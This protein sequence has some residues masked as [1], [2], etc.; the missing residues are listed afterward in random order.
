MDLYRNLIVIIQIQPY[1]KKLLFILLYMGICMCQIFS[2]VPQILKY[3]A[4]LRNVSGNP[5]ASSNKTIVVDILQGSTSGINVFSET[6]NV[7]TNESGIANLDIGSVNSAGFV[8]ID[9]SKG[10]YFLKIAVDGQVMGTSQ[11]LSVPY[12]LYADKTGKSDKLEVNESPTLS[13]DSALFEVKDKNGNIVF[14]V[15]ENGVIISYNEGAKGAR[16][17]FTVGGRT[18]GKG[19]MIENIF[20]VTTDSVRIYINDSSLLKGARGGFTVGGRIRSKGNLTNEYLTITPDSTRI[21]INNNASK[22]SRGGF[23]VGGRT[24]TKGVGTNFLMVTPDS[25]RIITSDTLK[26]FGVSTLQSGNTLGYLRLTPSNYLIGQQAGQNITTGLYNSIMG[27]KAGYSNTTGESNSF[28]GYQAGYSNTFGSENI[29]LGKKAGFSNTTGFGNVA[30]G[31]NALY[32]NTSGNYNVAEGNGALYSNTSGNYNVANG[33]FA[34]VNNTTGTYNVANG[35]YALFSNTTGWQNVANGFCAL[36]NNTTGGW[37][38]AIGDMAM[39]ANTTGSSNV[40]N[41]F[42]ALYS[43]TTGSGN[44]ADGI[45]ALNF[46]TTGWANTA[47]GEDALYSNTTGAYNVGVGWDA[48]FADTSGSY[49]V[50]VGYLAGWNIIG[51]SNVFIGCSAGQW[52]TSGSYNVAIGY[53]AGWHS[54][55]SSNVFIGPNAG[56]YEL[57]SNKLYIANKSGTPLIGG[58]F[59]TSKVGINRMPTTYTLEVGGT[60]WANGSTITA[61]STTWSDA[62]YKTNVIPLDNALN[63]VMNLQGV[64]FDWKRSEFPDLNFPKGNQIGVIAQD[65]EKI[66]P[67]LVYTGPDGY[68]SV[69]Y[70]KLTPVLIEAIKEQQQIIKK[71]QAEIDKL[72]AS[73]SEVN[74]LRSEFEQLKSLMQSTTA[75]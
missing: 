72:N 48:L 29:F 41:G 1:M 49:N 17:G 61:G 20:Q 25:T 45:S 36:Q 74:K 22:G 8:T 46:N 2:Q 4:V 12:A 10:P 6:Q 28:I 58:N 69:S 15:Y 21:Y 14:A 42:G 11:L 54:M 59:A 51:S 9:W 55:G 40:A 67:Q 64:Q 52:D 57:G 56:Q 68:K 70:E 32:S 26:G 35:F 43:N 50:A 53:A 16:G 71:Q 39:S 73:L 38:V 31:N 63:Y 65:V 23:A 62:R 34:L 27:Y 18:Q 66:L 3:Q 47:C 13:P 30:N 24:T 7:S 60:I 33:Y 75:K 37:N 44:L 5:L 19:N